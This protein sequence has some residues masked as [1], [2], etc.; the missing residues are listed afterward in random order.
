MLQRC[1]TPSILAAL[2]ALPLA[3]SAD[4]IRD[5]VRVNMRTG[6][7]SEHRILRVLVSGDRIARLGQEDGWVLVRTPEGK[8]GWVPTPYVTREV[9]PS[10]SLPKAQSDLKDARTQIEELSNQLTHQTADVQEL[11]ALRARNRL[12]ED[13]NRTLVRSD[14]WKK[15][16]T[17]AA[18]AGLFLAVGAMWPR[19]SAAQRTRRIKL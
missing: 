18:I 7:S 10:V 1:L 5:Q 3:A 13:E 16:F 8:E 17:G 9:P 15:W 14:N 19:G 11:G 12:L 2:C 4:Y 6:P